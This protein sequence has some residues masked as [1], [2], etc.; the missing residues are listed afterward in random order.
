[1]AGGLQT[2]TLPTGQGVALKLL[3]Q[4]VSMI[5]MLQNP[6]YWEKKIKIAILT[7][8]TFAALC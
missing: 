8:A 1:L 6:V 3:L 5:E 2:D 4:D 7:L